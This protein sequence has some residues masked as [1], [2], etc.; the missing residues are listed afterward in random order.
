[1]MNRQDHAA[2][3]SGIRTHRAPPA[4]AHLDTASGA[5]TAE[6]AL[7][8]RGASQPTRTWLSALLAGIFDSPLA[9][10]TSKSAV[11]QVSKPAGPAVVVTRRRFGNRRYSRLGNPRYGTVAGQRRICCEMSVSP[12]L[13]TASTGD[14]SLADF[15]TQ[16]PVPSKQTKRRSPVAGSEGILRAFLAMIM[17]A[18]VRLLWLGS[19]HLAQAAEASNCDLY[20]V[21]LSDQSLREAAPGTVLEDGLNG[22]QP[23]QFGWLTWG[24]SPSEPA[25]IASLTPPG[26]SAGYINPD[27]TSDH[28]VTIGDWI[29]A[30]PGVGNSARL[31]AALDALKSVDIIV[32]VW[33]ET[34]GTGQN[35]AY[36]VQTFARVRLLDYDLPRG[37]RLR[38]LFLGY[39]T[40][41]ARNTPPVVKAGPDQTLLPGETAA[42]SGSVSD[43]GLPAGAP[44]TIL[45]SKVSGPGDV[46]FANPEM[47][48]T[49]ASFSAEGVYELRL[50]AGDS[51]LTQSD[52]LI[53]TVNRPNR[54][55]TARDQRVDTDEDTA[56]NVR[57]EG[58]DPDA[59]PVSYALVSNPSYGT[60]SGT[61]PELTYT[62]TLDFNGADSFTFVTSDGLLD[63]PPATVSIT[64]RP[65]NDAPLADNQSFTNAEDEPLTITLS[66]SDVEG[67]ALTFLVVSGPSHGALTVS[68]PPDETG[69][70][71]TG[72]GDFSLDPLIYQPDPDFFG[73]DS[74]SFT[75]HDGEL[76]SEPATISIRITNVNDGPLVEAGPDQWFDVVGGPFAATLH[77]TVTDDG[78]PAENSLAVAWS[79]VSGPGTA[80]F[81][82]A[83][84]PDGIVQ[85][86]RPG[87]YR[88]RLTASDSVLAAQDEVEVTF[89]LPPT[90]NAGEDQRLALPH[91]A[92]L[93]GAV[94]DDG[95]PM[96][97][98]LFMEWSEIAG[99]GSTIFGDPHQ[100]ETTA[101][102]SAEGSYVLRLTAAD[103]AFTVFDD[104][105]INVAATN[106][107]P[108]IEAGAD[109]TV[110]LPEVAH[111]IGT[112]RDDGLPASGVLALGW[113]KVSGPG[114]VY[115][116][117]P[118]AA[119]SSASFSEPGAY[120]LRLS[121]GDGEFSVSDDLN[122][123]AEDNL[124]PRPEAGPDQVIPF[125]STA[126]P[127][128]G[129]TL[130]CSGKVVVNNDE[131]TLSDAGFNA[132][133]GA[134]QFARNLADWFTDG[135]PGN[136]LVYSDN[137]GLTQGRL[138][139]VM[140]EAGHTWTVS[141]EIDF[142]LSELAAY[143]AIFLAGDPADNQV[144]ID[145]VRGGGNVY[146]AGG[147]SQPGA[148]Q[149]AAQWNTFLEAFGFV[150]Q[151]VYGVTGLFPVTSS[152]PLLRFVDGLYYAGGNP[153]TE[154][155]P[156]NPV[157]TVLE[158]HLGEGLLAVF[159]PSHPVATLAG[160]VIDDGRPAETA[161]S[162]SWTQ[163]E[164]PATAILARPQ[165]ATTSVRFCEPGSY[166]FRLS[167]DDGELAGTDDVTI[168]VQ[169]SS[170]DLTEGCA[171][172][173][174]G[175]VSWFP[176]EG[177]LQDLKGGLTAAMIGQVNYEP[178]LVGQG[179]WFD[180][181]QG[182]IEVGA[183]AALDLGR[184]PG[185]TVETWIR[186]DDVAAQRPL[187]EWNSRTGFIGSHLWL[188]GSGRLV[189]HL[190]D[191]AGAFHSLF[192][193]FNVITSGTHHHVAAT[194][195]KST[196]WAR[197]FVDGQLAAE[198]DL[199]I[200]SPQTSYDLFFGYRPSGGAA[201]T[202]YSGLLDEVSFYDRALSASQVQSLF[203]AGR[204]GKCSTPALTV[205][206]G[207]DLVLVLPE[208][209]SLSAETD[210]FGVEN[211]PEIT[212]ELLEGPGPVVFNDP[213]R[214]TTTAQF[215]LAGIYRFRATA[216]Q[217]A[218]T[219]TDEMRVIVYPA[220][221]AN[222]APLVN[223]GPDR[224]LNEPF[225]TL[226]S[227]EVFDDGLPLGGEVS[228]LW[229]QVSGPAPAA[230]TH[231]D[232]LA[233][234]ITFPTD[235]N[236]VL[237][238]TADDTELIGSDDVTILVK[239]QLNQ[240]PMIQTGPPLSG[241][242]SQPI[243]LDFLVSDDYLPSGILLINWTQISGPGTVTFALDN[244]MWSARFDAPGSYQLQLTVTDTA[245]TNS[246]D[247]T[248]TV[249]PDSSFL[250]VE[251]GPDQTVPLDGFALLRGTVTAE[252][253]GPEPLGFAWSRVNGPGDVTWNGQRG[254]LDSTSI[255]S[256]AAFEMEGSY[257]LRLT[258][259]NSVQSASDEVTVQ[260]LPVS[261]IPVVEITSLLDSAIVTAPTVVTG[262][263]SSDI[264]QSWTFQYRPK[265]PNAE[266]DPNS[267]SNGGNAWIILAAGT[268]P[269][270]AGPLATFDPTMLLNGFYEIQLVARDQ[271]GRV[272][273]TEALPV[274]VDRNLKVGPF[275]LSFNDLTV[276]VAG[277]PIQ[278]IRTYD[279]RAARLGERG[280]FGV[281]WSLE[282]KNIRLR[283]SRSLGLAWEET[284]SGIGFPTYCLEPIR[285]RV[286]C[287]T[288]PGGRTYKFQATAVPPCQFGLPVTAASVL[289]FPIANTRGS[290][291]SAELDEVLVGGSI[292]GTVD[293]FTYDGTF[294]NPSLF[295][296]TTSE[297]DRYL[298]D[299]REGLK[300]LTDR[301]GNTLTVT[302]D[303]LIHS[304]GASVLFQRNDQG[305][306]TNIVDAAGHE[307]A[308]QYDPE[309]NLVGTTDRE[310]NHTALAY[311]HPAFT[312]Y[313]TEITA[314]NGISAVR[315][316]FDADG[317]LI[318]L[319]DARGRAV[320]LT[321]D[322]SA[323]R[324]I[325]Q[326]RLGRLTIHE[327]DVHGNVLAITDPQGGVTRFAYDENDNLVEQ[328]DAL[329]RTNRFAYDGND[330]PVA[331]TDPLGQTTRWTYD[332]YRSPT[333]VC[334]PLG[335]VTTNR[336]D[337]AGN[338]IWMRDALGAVTTFGFD[339]GQLAATTN[340]AGQVVRFEHD[341]SGF[342]TRTID[343]IGQE[344]A[345]TRDENGNLL[346]LT[347]ART[348]STGLETVETRFQYDREN[349]LT[350]TI[351]ADGSLA[352]TLYDPLGRPTLLRD[353]LGRETRLDYDDLGRPVRTTFPDGGIRGLAYDEGDRL[354]AE[355]NQLGLATHY[356]YDALDRLIRVTRPD[357]A[358]A[359]YD[360]DPARQLL[361]ETDPRGYTTWFAYDR[362]GRISSITNALGQAVS[363]GYDAAGNLNEMNDAA[364]RVTRLRY[365]AL[366]RPVQVLW[367]DGSS[368]EVAYDAL[369]RAV[370][371][372]DPNGKLTG[373][374][375]D[376]LGRLVAVTN[377]LG[378]ITRYAYDE[379][380]N[381]VSQTDANQH[382]T[383]FAYDSLG[384]PTRRTLPEGQSETLDY[385]LAGNVSH[386][387]DFNGATTAFLYDSMDRIL[388]RVPDPVLGQ[389]AV[390]HTYDALGRR[391]TMADATGVTAYAYDAVNRLIQK[392]NGNGTVNYDY[393]PNGNVLRIASSTPNGA[394]V[395]YE[396]DPLNRLS[397]ARDD[398]LGQT[399]YTYDPSGNPA[400]VSYPNGVT[401][402]HRYDEM[403]HVT[404]IIAGLGSDL[405]VNY[406]YALDAEGRRLRAMEQLPAS[407]IHPYSSTGHGNY[408][409][410]NVYQLTGEHH[411]TDSP[412][413]AP[414][415]ST[416][417]EWSLLYEYDPV[418][419][420]LSRLSTFDPIPSAWS[421][422]SAN[423]ELNTDS[424]DLN[425]NTLTSAGLSS[426]GPDRYD[427][428][429]HLVERQVTVGNQP[430]TVTF[431]YDGHGN[432]VSKTVTTPL[433]S[434]TT[435][436]LVDDL[437]P[438]GYAQVLY[439]RA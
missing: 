92:Q 222:Q 333:S 62:P 113:T 336:Y 274:I 411:V 352:S 262:T 307:L 306:I 129:S 346:E 17:L 364:G 401:V 267:A 294:Y 228:F 345:F 319:I 343:S 367:P 154:L 342:L 59:D 339:R 68:P 255:V 182:H 418:G 123:L 354:I 277:I 416:P 14:P 157:T 181:L 33:N 330:N 360:Y 87:R 395:S 204:A 54:P 221:T 205:E 361:A 250:R 409:Y 180:G 117:D 149:E 169:A 141:R 265:P 88:L 233:T 226:L 234:S 20:P 297:G 166:R 41:G 56:V 143:D 365:D 314:P 95:F 100:P 111:L 283:K 142:S 79:Q 227:G 410:D 266:V 290:L 374:A 243:R 39:A 102:F 230:V 35:A 200:F 270:S 423:D 373:Y 280:D 159:E 300:R 99:P 317:R 89:N 389:P 36:R 215:E 25:L 263:V 421:V 246:A 53:V 299:E 211:Q 408:S 386:R 381:L 275:T 202:R 338:L 325:L 403:N 80:L 125:D 13:Q 303:G 108:L 424:Y 170:P 23:G 153:V 214:Q 110:H 281:G 406:S 11:A 52:D 177:H 276:P 84:E 26:D 72:A 392:S 316:E 43:D 6:S 340:A 48:V 268:T 238:L 139:E 308:Y 16:Q 156:S 21:A 225:V 362:A 369:G 279:S 63:S 379:E 138:A 437:N 296:F 98:P 245:L 240:A 22:Q 193:G 264:L 164:G 407:P 121:G 30:K 192:T 4:R 425:G 5:G 337:A 322:L 155:V 167:A 382:T 65:V 203:E 422:Y 341:S 209:V 131:W 286:V 217:A 400:S 134:A 189:L 148:A 377:A 430:V 232:A 190:Q 291:R 311:S 380:G 359:T 412:P 3:P 257:V 77:G 269:V 147:T 151:P 135:A 284:G 208:S 160:T 350:N 399:G 289:Y 258:V 158:S 163:L 172:P 188:A 168:E 385:D 74:F 145:Y 150:F 186:P 18:A 220:Q 293:L 378:H 223:A 318:R 198:A 391:L 207:P 73:A 7:L 146:L 185:L 344:R 349:R 334:D 75:V 196:G 351:F 44:L 27:Q 254:W 224:T 183:T 199:G 162:L 326:D 405:I 438:T 420:R 419:N 282:I 140:I 82:A 171:P 10:Q 40:C 247:L 50:T 116:N 175:L 81:Q 49:S 431:R 371:E 376:A 310:S 161:L 67:D 331:L 259:S 38:F 206:A 305:L 136:F 8:N 152:H 436:Y 114:Q 320:E 372:I 236:Y 118:A 370:A 432:R 239:A 106:Q 212:W 71:Q 278:V 24:G 404:N 45:W 1:M 323:Q 328:I 327:Y 384:R 46:L 85:F 176:A 2:E 29:Q 366:N 272:S 109:Q 347:S 375:H 195:D 120:L 273:A 60:L 97:V 42:L 285:P 124:G 355:T 94:T 173:P 213:T 357:G 249:E 428:E 402:L 66:G 144:L 313:L 237:R 103:S 332:A 194:Y 197:I 433:E 295:E 398:H 394:S 309:G 329:G 302:P 324:E 15:H 91:Q 130:G 368:E 127:S 256:T 83:Q 119:E 19:V 191:E 417:G 86:T 137:F 260:A 242:Q 9:A 427:F 287:L 69:A 415:E 28:Q 244:E 32:P 335:H 251:A 34:R 413:T 112:A 396:Y 128:G 179:W 107:A 414:T 231:S 312:H 434:D 216:R 201:G 383:Q 292:P 321:H 57:L 358:S 261:P 104:V 174:L 288:M 298:V 64:I 435:Y 93:T 439:N 356:D 393:D 165:S 58:E 184:G 241:T 70:P 219:A 132:A 187:I 253:T 51:E 387:T 388:A 248:V 133:P 235:G 61:A 390:T 348:T 210:S 55:P 115:F 122:I 96:G 101:S 78:L 315:S 12:G 229:S 90:V 47:A 429:G 397:V 271:A 304:S 218:L 353:G 178:A 426:S 301:N 363:R 105:E 252:N 31:R 126:N 76:E 37:N